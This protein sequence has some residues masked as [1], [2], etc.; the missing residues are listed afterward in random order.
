[1]KTIDLTQLDWQWL[2]WRPWT[3]KLRASMETGLQLRSDLGPIAAVLPGTVQEA[4]RREGVLDD[5]LVGLNSR[6]C[7]WVEHRHWELF[8]KLSADDVA[9]AR[10][11]VLDANGLDHSGWILVDAQ[12]VA[13]FSGVLTPTLIDLTEY[14]SD[15]Q[16][17]FL[18]IVFDEPPAEQGQIGF[19]SLSKHFKPRYNYSWDW[20]PRLVPIGVW[21]HLR[22][23]ADIASEF[24][25][26]KVWT[27]LS[28]DL[29][30]GL[31]SITLS[32]ESDAP[33]PGL[34]VRATLRHGDAVVVSE[35]VSVTGGTEEWRI[36]GF[37]VSPWWPNGEGP[38]KLYELTVELIAHGGEVLLTDRRRVG[39]RHVRWV[40]CEGAPEDAMPWICEVNGKPIFLQGV[41]WSPVRVAYPDTQDE[42]YR[43]RVELYREMGCNLL[44]VWGGAYLGTE[45][46]FQA[47][48]GA[49]ILVWQEFPL[50][51]SGI[52]NWPP[53]DPD[54][55]ERLQVIARSYIGRRAHHPSLLMWCGGNELQGSMDG[56]KTGGGLPARPDHPCLAAFAEVVRDEDPTRRFLHTSASGPRF[57]AD[58]SEFGMGVNH[59]VHGPWGF[60]GNM[61]GFKEYWRGDDALFRAEVGVPGACDVDLIKRYYPDGAWWPPTNETW[62]HSCLWWLMWDQYEHL[63]DRDPDE[64]LA[65]YVERTQANQAEGYAFAARMCKQRFPRCGGFVIW[66]GHDC[67]PCAVNNSVIDVEGKPKPAYY[68]LKEVFTTPAGE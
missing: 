52:D 36:E 10:R 6:A 54:V 21:G 26:A 35:E 46:F 51:S 67:Y 17:H 39:F 1:M 58:A 57:N 16:D 15:G 27:D 43:Q 28:E 33:E 44:R 60:D 41:N 29:Q 31:M 65:E 3:W 66:H 14:L 55:I 19:T 48:D 32:Y 38:A 12:E 62:A 25:V 7:E 9:G 50:S 37:Q 20:C 34:T 13:S 18:S 2:G 11:I 30:A 42:E 40:P 5:W 23:T 59:E 56:G 4:L 63:T 61:A 49:G 8:T 22:L 64:A 45:A 53:E 24:R 68:A 47:C